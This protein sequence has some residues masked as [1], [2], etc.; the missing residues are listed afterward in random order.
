MLITKIDDHLF[1]GVFIG[2]SF[3]VINQMHADCC[4]HRRTETANITVNVDQ[5]S[6]HIIF[7][8]K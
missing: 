4:I 8:H 7:S 1:L 3:N 5:K 2:Y 6:P